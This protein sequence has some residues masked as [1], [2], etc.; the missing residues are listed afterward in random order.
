MW[1]RGGDNIQEEEVG[2]GNIQF[3]SFPEFQ[4][5][6]TILNTIVVYTETFGDPFNS[7]LEVILCLTL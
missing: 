6:N 5:S 3:T 4:L 2:E 1:G 7:L